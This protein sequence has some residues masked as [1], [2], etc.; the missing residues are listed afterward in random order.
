MTLGSWIVPVRR[1]HSLVTCGAFIMSRTK[2]GHF[3]E[4]FEMAFCRFPREGQTGW[5]RFLFFLSFFK[6]KNW[7]VKS[8]MQDSSK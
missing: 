8:E 1:I 7:Q 5:H 3:E 2:D 4:Y 6:E